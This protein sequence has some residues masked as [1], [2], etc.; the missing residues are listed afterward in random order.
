MK[1]GSGVGTYPGRK[2]VWRESESVFEAPSDTVAFEPVYAKSNLRMHA[3]K[4]TMTIT[5][6]SLNKQK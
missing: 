2:E 5:V 6:T 3:E 1:E 4:F